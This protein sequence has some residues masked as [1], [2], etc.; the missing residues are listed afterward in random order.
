MMMVDRLRELKTL[1]E[2]AQW[3]RAWAEVAGSD[4]E[5]AR[6]IALAEL[7]ERKIAVLKQMEIPVA[8]A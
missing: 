4:H 7:V 6:R 2:L 3:Y 8:A 1:I 5:R